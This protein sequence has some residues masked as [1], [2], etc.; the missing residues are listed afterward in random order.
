MTTTN[1]DWWPDQ[2]NLKALRQNS[3]LSDPDGRGFRLRRGRQD[4][5]RRGPEAGHR[6]GDDDLAG[7]V[8]G[9][10][11]PLR[12]SLHPHDLARRRHL[13]YQRRPRRGR[14]R[15]PALRA[16]QQLAGQRQPRQGAPPALAGQEEVRPQPLLGR[17]DHF[18][19]QLRPRVDGVQDLRL[20]LR[21]PGCLGGGRDGLGLGD[22]V[23]GRRAPRRRGGAPGTARGRPHGPDLRESGGAERQ[24]GPGPGGEVHPPDVQPHGDERRGDG[25]P[26]RRRTHLRQG[27]RR[28]P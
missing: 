20:R 10:L 14:L 9:R 13:P 8:A 22:D 15:R 27:A 3:P 17:P 18:R 26:H 23:A 16:P 5:R 24:P 21:A 25:R 12:A 1:Q 7:L 2:L 19:R 28:R 4:P 11:R 6:R